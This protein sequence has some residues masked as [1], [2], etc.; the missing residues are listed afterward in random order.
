LKIIDV[1]EVKSQ[2]PIA[3]VVSRFNEDITR[4]LLEGATKRLKEFGFSNDD[5]TI[6]W[7]P[8]AIEIP[9]AAQRLAQ[10]GTF[11]AIVCLGAVIRGETSH[12]D[13]V[14]EQVSQGAQHVALQNDLPVI[15]G[16]LTTENED[17]ARDRLGGKHGHK[18]REAIDT[19]VEIVNVLKQI[20]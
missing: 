18:G 3:L 9:I 12:Y 4:L 8:G 20:G 11:E 7:V 15:F 17:Q 2:F 13:Y 19:A 1:K 10:L 5:I 6:V 16:V 14:C